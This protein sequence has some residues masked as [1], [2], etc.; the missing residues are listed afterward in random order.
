MMQWAW[1]AR[2]RLGNQRVGELA[3]NSE[4][5][6]LQMTHRMGLYAARVRPA[7]TLFACKAHTG[8][9]NKH[10]TTKQVLWLTQQLAFLCNAGLPILNALDVLRI[11]P[12]APA[13][14]QLV[15]QLHTHLHQGMP[16]PQAFSA[17]NANQQVFSNAY[18]GSLGAAQRSGLLG[19]A[20]TSL[21]DQ[22]QFTATLQAQVRS[23]VAYPVALMLFSALIVLG[24]LVLVVPAFESQFAQ[25]GI[26]LPW[27]TAWLLALSRWLLTHAG[28]LAGGALAS[29]VMLRLWLVRNQLK[30]SPRFLALQQLA[31]KGLLSLPLVGPIVWQVGA[32]QW[33]HNCAHLLATGLPLLD[34]LMH[35]S[36]T[37][38]NVYLQHRLGSVHAAV[39]AGVALSTSLQDA[40]VFH[41]NVWAVCAVGE[42]TG[43]LTQAL[44]HISTMLKSELTQQLKT[45]TS[46]LEPV[47]VLV[48]GVMIGAIVLAMYWPIFELGRT[49]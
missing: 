30:P 6:A 16:L 4:R 26:A 38:K 23:A 10:L 18:V 41:A 19:Q 21:A 34:A 11:Q 9:H 28:L 45:F 31:H 25:Q 14:Q 32:A 47:A 15:A 36:P 22:L 29:L 44:Q 39:S 46:L 20:F 12:L 33:S 2:D 37:L 43:N 8:H 17:C 49:V 5:A 24:L 27:P 1:Q 35:T 40:Q 3:A 13:L 48:V 42:A 7:R